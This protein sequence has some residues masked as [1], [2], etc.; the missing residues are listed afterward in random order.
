V[1]E[2]EVEILLRGRR[3]TAGWVVK[4]LFVRGICYGKLKREKESEKA[5]DQLVRAGGDIA[6]LHFLLGKA[7]LDL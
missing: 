3:C 7:Y 6:H 1:R 2:R 5:F 4:T